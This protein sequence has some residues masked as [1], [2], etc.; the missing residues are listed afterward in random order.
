MHP[1]PGGD[2]GAPAS[3][4][5]SSRIAGRHH[6]GCSG[7]LRR[8]LHKRSR[9]VSRVPS[10]MS[11]AR[12][13]GELIESELFGHEGAF[14]GARSRHKA[15]AEHADNGTLLPSSL[16]GAHTTSASAER[17]SRIQEAA[18]SMQRARRRIPVAGI[19]AHFPWHACPST[20][21]RHMGQ[22]AS[23]RGSGPPSARARVLMMT[24]TSR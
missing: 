18:S 1:R 21:A 5:T 11:I 14:T 24:P 19:S 2:H 15:Y 13:S 20:H 17:P 3:Q 12:R 7:R 10:V 23:R 4:A 8:N 16:L 9:P 6:F 22:G